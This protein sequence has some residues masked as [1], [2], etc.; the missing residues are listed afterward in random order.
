M[1]TFASSTNTTIGAPLSTS[2]AKGAISYTKIKENITKYHWK[3]QYDESSGAAYII[4]GTT[5]ITYDSTKSIA[6]KAKYVLDN[7]L[8]GIMFWDLSQDTTGD[9]LDAIDVTL[10]K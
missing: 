10:N 6:A 1:G 9:L 5:F 4:E 8:G 3:E 2:L 7:N